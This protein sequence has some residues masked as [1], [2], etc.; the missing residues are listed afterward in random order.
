MKLIIPVTTDHL[1]RKGLPALLAVG[2]A[3]LL[4]ACGGGANPTAQAE[5]TPPVSETPAVTLPP[6]VTATQTAQ[7]TTTL[8]PT[9]TPTATPDTRPDPANWTIWPV[10][11]TVSGTAR[12]I[13]R[14]GQELGNNPHY[15]SVIGDCQSLP[16]TFMGIYDDGGYFLGEQYAYL[17]DTI[18]YFAG[19][20]DAPRLAAKD[21]MLPAT[22]LSPTW[23][24]S[25]VCQADET[26]V[27]CELRVNKPAFIFIA[28]GTNWPAQT[29][30][31]KFEKY[32]RQVLD[33]V[34]AAGTLP[35]L[36]TK[37]DD[38]EG[39]N[40]I[41]MVVVKLAYEYD[42]PLMNFWQVAQL[43]PNGG[44]DKARENIYL[45]IEG[46]NLHSF[47]GLQTLDAVWKGVQGE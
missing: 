40:T 30:T 23:A 45:T 29:T 42:I 16:E 17:Q 20:F 44:L 38:A 33:K 39:G 31:E 46:W 21:G 9:I 14:R 6:T 2:L 27:D 36:A 4:A 22:A 24:D 34:I 32:M 35:I 3:L 25:S 43:L 5:M 19:S 7:P 11:P 1:Y 47:T 26:P 12:D 13:Y 41:N 37:A 8:T 18:D 28:L 10:I 15:F